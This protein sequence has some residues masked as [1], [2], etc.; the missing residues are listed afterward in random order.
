MHY[1]SDKDLALRYSIHKTTVWRWARENGFPKP[2]KVL[3]STR[4]KKQDIEQWEKSEG[5]N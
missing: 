2:V 1:F 4:W 3:N 5:I